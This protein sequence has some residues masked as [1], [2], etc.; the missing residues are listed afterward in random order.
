MSL[1][2]STRIYTR[3]LIKSVHFQAFYDEDNRY[4]TNQDMSTALNLP[5]HKV[6]WLGV[7]ENPGCTT[8]FDNEPAHTLKYAFGIPRTLHRRGP[9]R[10]R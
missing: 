3:A 5:H 10:G 4:P 8:F 1:Y 9:T 2:F 7:R 6:A